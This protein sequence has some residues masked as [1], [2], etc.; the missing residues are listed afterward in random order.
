MLFGFDTA[1]ISGATTA[2]TN[3]FGLSPAELGFTVAIAL[4]GTVVGSI[5]AGSLEARYGG[6][7]MLR[8][9]AVL[10]LFS[11]IGCALAP[12]W[13]IFLLARIVGGIGVGGSSVL[14]PVYIAEIAPARLRGRL[15]GL[16]QINIVIGVLA[17]YLS[18]YSIARA[19]LGAMEWRW[20][21]GVA[22]L[23]AALFLVLLFTIPRSARWLIARERPEKHRMG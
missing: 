18:N 6:R 7:A 22:A 4:A 23:P 20:E 2:L 8:V 19:N 10:Y 14:G 21:F 1:V 9:M 11:A 12:T 3:V 16:F 5:S 17:A 15:V 13:T